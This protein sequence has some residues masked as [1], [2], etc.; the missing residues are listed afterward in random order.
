MPKLEK[1]AINAVRAETIRLKPADIVF[2]VFRFDFAVAKLIDGTKW[3]G[4]ESLPFTAKENMLVA[5]KIADDWGI[6]SMKVIS[7]K[8]KGDIPA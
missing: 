5:V 8:G 1:S 3:F 2:A 7:I 6:E 4:I